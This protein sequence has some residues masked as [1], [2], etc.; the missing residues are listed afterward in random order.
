MKISRAFTLIELL[1][2]MVIMGFSLALVGPF[3]VDQIDKTKA[4][5]EVKRLEQLI[6]STAS[7]AYLSG[8]PV[9]LRFNGKSLQRQSGLQSNVI[10]FEYLFFK[11]TEYVVNANGEFS[12]FVLELTAHRVTRQIVIGAKP[13]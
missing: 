2:V 10:D 12:E 7:L 13:N 1:V 5:A 6:D 4:N 11:P 9:I 3:V 8:Q